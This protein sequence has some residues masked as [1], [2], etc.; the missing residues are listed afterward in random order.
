MTQLTMQR[1]TPGDSLPDGTRCF[2][3]YRELNC[4]DVKAERQ[5]LNESL[6]IYPVSRT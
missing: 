6:F 2:M 1:E 3:Q 4:A 5:F